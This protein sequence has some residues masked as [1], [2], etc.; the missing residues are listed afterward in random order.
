MKKIETYID[1]AI[2]PFN[3]GGT[4]TYG[5]YILKPD[6]STME[7]WG[8]VGSGDLYSNN[9]AE[10]AALRIALKLIME[11]FDVMKHL[12]EFYSDSQLVVMQMKRKWDMKGGLY[13][14]E[15]QRCLHLAT[16]FPNITYT[17]IP[18]EKNFY[19]DE[20]SKRALRE[21]GL[22]PFGG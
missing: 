5:V 22:T 8:V 17:W 9:V 6:G 18:R 21:A 4:A 13:F 14:D 1:G 19:A 2:G 10:Y 20:L 16:A 11:K 12:V 15:A 7:D 3:P